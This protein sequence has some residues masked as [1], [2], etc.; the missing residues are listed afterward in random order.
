MRFY[1]KTAG[2]TK[3]T[4][5]QKVEDPL[6][7][8]WKARTKSETH[9]PC[10]TAANPGKDSIFPQHH[11]LLAGPEDINK[12]TFITQCQ[13]WTNTAEQVVKMKDWGLYLLSSFVRQHSELHRKALQ[14][15]AQG[16]PGALWRGQ[17]GKRRGIWAQCTAE[18]T[19]LQREKVILWCASCQTHFK[20]TTRNRIT[21]NTEDLNLIT[22]NSNTCGYYRKIKFIP[23]IIKYL[24]SLPNMRR[25]DALSLERSTI[26]S[27]LSRSLWK[28]LW[29]FLI[30]SLLVENWA[31]MS[32]GRYSCN[33]SEAKLFCA[34]WILKSR[35]FFMRKVQLE[36]S[37][38]CKPLPELRFC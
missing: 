18:N 10:T 3:V 29:I 5:T 2:R 19:I 13:F 20:L 12:T 36:S 7:V 22:K 21:D 30:I 24:S 31:W 25:S 11:L 33:T 26:F 27:A 4:A 14:R 17:G 32:A 16:P 28:L 38:M 37:T 9:S 6:E 35:Q 23:V 34:V 15:L 1:Q 8:E